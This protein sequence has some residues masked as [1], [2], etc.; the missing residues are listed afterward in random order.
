MVSLKGGNDITHDGGAAIAIVI[1]RP[2][3]NATSEVCSNP[4]SDDGGNR[5]QGG[6]SN[7]AIRLRKEGVDCIGG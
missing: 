3:E 4:A 1:N 2:V 5:C 6:Y 7:I